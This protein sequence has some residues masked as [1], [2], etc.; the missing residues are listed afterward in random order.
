MTASSLSLK[1][2]GSPYSIS[3]FEG[4]KGQ[5]VSIRVDSLFEE[6]PPYIVLLNS[7][8]QIVAAD[9]DKDGRYTALIDRAKLPEDGTYYVVVL[10]AIPQQKGAY[11]L[12]VF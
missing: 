1:K 2:N 8:G 11:R 7:K 4:K 12:T 3:K 9:N 5:L 10:S 6:F